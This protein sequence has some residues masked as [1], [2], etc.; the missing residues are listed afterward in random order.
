MQFTVNRQS[1]AAELAVLQS[2]AEK[3]GTIP[4]LSFVLFE[5]S[6]NE[7]RIT[8]TD[9]DVTIIATVPVEND[10][11][12]AFCVPLRQLRNLVSLIKVETVS[13]REGKNDR[14]TI[15]WAD[16]RHQLPTQTRDQFPQI[17]NIGEAVSVVMPS[18]I[19]R[20]M[21]QSAFMAVATEPEENRAAFISL[22]LQG[23]N[24]ALEITGNN[25]KHVAH[26]SY[27]AVVDSPFSI[28]LPRRAAKELPSFLNMDGDTQIQIASNLIRFITGNRQ[29]LSRLMDGK[30]PDWKVIIPAEEGARAFIPVSDLALATKRA[31]I[32]SDTDRGFYRLRFGFSKESLTVENNETVAGQSTESVAIDCPSLNGNQWSVSLN[33]SHVLGFLGLMDSEN[34]YIEFWADG[35]RP[36][37]FAP[38]DSAINFQYFTSPCKE[39]DSFAILYATP[40]LTVDR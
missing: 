1:L 22:H 8:A 9:M 35:V 16:S 18:Q 38:M 17:E 36:V 25:G 12:W 31:A 10:A 15:R 37:R 7:A 34:A 21:A 33:G 23:E 14:V 24:G 39:P 6:N 26:T 11:D 20:D 4:I 40:V 2:A 5:V 28:L 13:I 32:T 30:F 3:K 19:L 27:P 29:F